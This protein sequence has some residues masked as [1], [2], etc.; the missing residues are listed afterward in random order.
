[1]DN[2]QKILFL[3]VG[4]SA[5]SQIAEALF[6]KMAIKN[7]DCFSAGSS[8]AEEVNPFA[9]DVLENY[10]I[11]IRDAKP[12]S[13]LE[14][15]HV[16]FDYVISLCEE[17]FEN[18]PVIMTNAVKLRW[19]L[20]DPVN[21]LKNPDLAKKVFRQTL[22]SI[23]NRLNNFIALSENPEWRIKRISTRQYD[24][25][26]DHDGKLI[27]EFTKMYQ[28]SVNIISPVESNMICVHE[29]DLRLTVKKSLNLGRKYDLLGISSLFLTL[30]VT[31]LTADFH[32]FVLKAITWEAI[33]FILS[34]TS[35]FWL[36]RSIYSYLKSLS[37][38]EI[39]NKIIETI[40]NT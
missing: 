13:W 4:N 15:K 29:S 23:R 26:K 33:F 32:D 22:L 9:I 39:E 21:F 40:K 14:F 7:F 36:I 19:E 24:L 20:P 34:F 35:L 27:D 18:C 28:K 10:G 38:E 17:D 16:E 11:D 25:Q 6:N 1:M 3:C 30:I 5:R 37:P 31:F 2:R 12:K 8:P